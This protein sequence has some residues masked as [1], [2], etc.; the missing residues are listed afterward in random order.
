MKTED[1]EAKRESISSVPA[2][3]KKYFGEK[4][5]EKDTAQ[6]PNKS[7][8]MLIQQR[9]KETKP[10]KENMNLISVVS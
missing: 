2:V 7:T 5:K 1:N 3:L 9:L 4:G 8:K 10:E 6:K